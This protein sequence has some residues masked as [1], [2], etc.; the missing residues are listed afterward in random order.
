M[1]LRGWKLT[2]SPLNMPLVIF[3][4]I[5]FISFF[6]GLVWRDPSL[7]DWSGRFIYVQIGA[8]LA[9]VLS[10]AAALL[11]GNFVTTPGQ[12]KY[13]IGVFIGVFCLMLIVSL[14]GLSQHVLVIRGLWSLWL[15]APVYALL[16]AQPRLRGWWRALLVLVLILTFY[17]VLI[18]DSLWVSGWLPG[19]VAIFAVTFLQSRKA[20]TIMVIAAALIYQVPVVNE[21]YKEAA[22][23]N[24]DEGALQR[25]S[26]WKQNWL[27]VRSHW[28][29]GTGP[30]G[31]AIYYMTYYREDARSTHNNYL[32]ILAQFGFVGMATWLWLSATC[33][34]EGWRLVQRASPGF[35]R[36]LAIAATGGWV[37]AMASMFLGD[38]VLPFAYN[39]TITGFKYT[40]YS[41]IF[42]GTLI[43]IRRLLPAE[44]KP[45]LRQWG[46]Q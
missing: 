25:I 21:F 32:D 45:Q 24:I 16:I 28:L 34:W 46:R 14:L 19:I 26:I 29:L 37:G 17:Q 10:L 40:V 13:L 7:L 12:L 22:Q 35:L 2:A 31:Y 11:I 36:T 1:M 33:L 39:Q 5:C 41:W 44:P 6:W 20:F 15:I 30:A 3:S 43:S 42:L 9:I 8:L 38:W 4:G 23:E 18:R 27:V